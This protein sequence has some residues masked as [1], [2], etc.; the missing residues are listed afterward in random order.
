MTAPWAYICWTGNLHGIF[1]TRVLVLEIVLRHFR[2]KSAQNAHSTLPQ[3]SL[4]KKYVPKEM[5]G[6]QIFLF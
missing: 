4:S 6:K 3:S 1:L 2:R 5:T